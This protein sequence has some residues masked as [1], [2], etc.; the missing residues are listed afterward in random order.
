MF[1]RVVNTP[2]IPQSPQKKQKTKK[3]QKA[4]KQRKNSVTLNAEAIETIYIFPAKQSDIHH[5][6]YYLFSIRYT[7]K[8]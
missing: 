6:Q 7:F 4:K 5:L 3:K 1:D 2:L 8:I